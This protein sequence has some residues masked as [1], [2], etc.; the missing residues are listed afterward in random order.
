MSEERKS[1]GEIFK[2][3]AEFFTATCDHYHQ[4]VFTTGHVSQ[5]NPSNPLK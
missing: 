5:E 1:G 2:S 3:V 4:M